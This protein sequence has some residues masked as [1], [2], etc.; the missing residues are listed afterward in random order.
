MATY[1]AQ[2]RTLTARPRS[3]RL[4]Q[5][6]GSGMVVGGGTGSAFGSYLPASE[7][8]NGYDVNHKTSFVQNI[9]LGNP[10]TVVDGE[11]VVNGIDIEFDSA[12]GAVHIKGGLYADWVSAMGANDSSSGSGGGGLDESAL[13]ELLN[14]TSTPEYT[15]SKIISSSYLPSIALSS[16]YG[17]LPVDRGGTGATTAA[18]ALE[19]LIGSS[20]IG[21]NYPIYWTGSSFSQLTGTLSNNISGK[22]NGYTISSSVSAGT[23]NYLA[24][25]SAANEISSVAHYVD[26]THLAINNITQPSY[27]FFVNGTSC[28][29]STVLIT[30]T[31]ANR[32]TLKLITNGDYPNDFILGTNN[33]DR[34]SITCRDSTDG[35][36]GFYNYIVGAYR[37]KILQ[38]GN[39]GIGTDSPSCMLDVSGDVFFGNTTSASHTIS[40]QSSAAQ[41]RMFAWSDGSCYIEG[42]NSSFTGNSA[43]AKI[44]ITGQGGINLSSIELRANN[45]ICNGLI[46]TV[47][48]G[49]TTTIGSQNNGWCHIYNS[50]DIPFIFNKSI[51]SAGANTDVGSALG[52]YN[53]PWHV[54]YLGGSTSA[55]MT[56]ATTNPRI[57]FFESNSTPGSGGSQAVALTYT[58]YD[59][60]RASKGLKVH[61][62]DGSD[63]GNVWLEVQGTCYCN[64]LSSS[65]Y[66]TAL[67]SNSSDKRLKKDIKP[68]NAMEIVDK[69]VPVKFRWN[70]H[71]Q[72]YNCNFNNGVNYGLIAQDC[73]GIIDDMVF[74]LPD[75]SGYKGVRYE[76][77]IPVLL[78]AIKELKLMVKE[79]KGE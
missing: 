18:D 48:S 32:A 4:R 72:K 62:M 6:V 25:Y 13:W 57:V 36:L 42:A 14:G 8:G 70:K 52:S 2:T 47:S 63:Y 38:N 31:N 78:Q 67:A 23:A 60:Y 20:S 74:D 75:G 3:E 30:S 44:Y 69:L 76:K 61:D 16:T 29:N 22:V 64:G 35:G 68:F 10:D 11:T 50:A 7:N 51:C 1:T 19:N 40:L 9:R 37:M 58:D 56:N 66:V 53:Y 39:V 21:G 26:S 54:L 71:A 49:N 45:T 77:L 41:L 65:S 43:T 12:T 59:S 17:T 46:Q 5:T 34:W 33:V 79:L 24:Y 28:L 27:N 15:G 55:T 73:D